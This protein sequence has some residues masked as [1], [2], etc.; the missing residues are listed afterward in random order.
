[1]NDIVERLRLNA[2]PSGDWGELADRLQI[3]A[4]DEIERLRAE[5][6]LMTQGHDSALRTVQRLA[7]EVER[8]RVEVATMRELLR[9]SAEVVEAECKEWHDPALCYLLKCIRAALGE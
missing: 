6:A 2:G 1:M 5:L 3:E 8:L 7:A 4:A 9:R